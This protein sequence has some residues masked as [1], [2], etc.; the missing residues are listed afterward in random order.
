MTAPAVTH[1][2]RF[3]SAEP[4]GHAEQLIRAGNQL[5]TFWGIAMSHNRLVKHA[6]RWQR[7]VSGFTWFDYLANAVQVD[8]TDRRRARARGDLA[9]TLAYADPTGEKA[10]RVVMRAGGGHDSP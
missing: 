7:E 8:D 6:R 5:L 10:V 3:T 9:S 1:I 4:S 2:R